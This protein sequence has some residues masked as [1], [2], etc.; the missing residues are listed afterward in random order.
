VNQEHGVEPFVQRDAGIS[1][2]RACPDSE[3]LPAAIA[4]VTIVLWEMR[5]VRVVAIGVG[6]IA[7]KFMNDPAP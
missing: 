4:L 5:R 6:T 7:E 3:L 2:D 1:E